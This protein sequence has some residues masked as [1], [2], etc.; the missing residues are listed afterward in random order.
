MI[1]GAGGDVSLDGEVGEEGV[2]I[3]AA[4]FSGVDPLSVDIASEAEV[5]VVPGD[6]GFFSPFRDVECAHFVPDLVEE[7]R[8]I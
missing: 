7:F 1:L 6:I 5:A 4:E 8:L 2:D 3:L